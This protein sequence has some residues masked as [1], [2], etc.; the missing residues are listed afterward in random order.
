MRTTHADATGR[1][2][3]SRLSPLA[4]SCPLNPLPLP[5]RVHAYC[6]RNK[7]ESLPPHFYTLPVEVLKLAGNI[8]ASLSDAVKGLSALR[9]LVSA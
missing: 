7:I 6:S 4:L 9:E 8:L 1:H 2:M 5:W 3:L